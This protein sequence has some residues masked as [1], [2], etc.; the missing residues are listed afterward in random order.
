M[1]IAGNSVGGIAL[2]RLNSAIGQDP[3]DDP[4]VLV[5]DDQVAR[6]RRGARD[7]RHRTAG[8]LRPRI[9]LVDG[10]E[11]LAVVAERHAR[12][13]RGP[14]TKYAHHGPTPLLAVAVRYWAIRGESFE[15]GGCS[16]WPT[17]APAIAQ[18]ALPGEA[19]G[20]T[21]ATAPEGSA[22]CRRLAKE[23]GAALAVPAV[24]SVARVP[25]AAGAAAPPTAADMAAASG[26]TNARSS[27]S[28]RARASGSDITPGH[29]TRA[30]DLDLASTHADAEA[31]E[32]AG[33]A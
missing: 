8:A 33:R 26:G 30:R 16:D 27:C 18:I 13:A 5:E 23:D 6:A 2:D 32:A 31:A 11:A 22:P 12:L 19:P 3:L 20:A 17:S 14:R 25:F 24:A 28:M 7:V 29:R 4:D 21:P 1:H 15:P 10:A 9:E